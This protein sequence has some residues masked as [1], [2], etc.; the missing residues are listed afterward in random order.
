[1]LV[2]VLLA[3]GVDPGYLLQILWPMA[4]ESQHLA[5]FRGLVLPFL[6]TYVPAHADFSQMCIVGYEQATLETL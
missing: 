5:H 1:M 4:A 6:Y 3:F 2:G